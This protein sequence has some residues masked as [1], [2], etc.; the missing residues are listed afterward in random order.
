[1]LRCFKMVEEIFKAKLRSFVVKTCIYCQLMKL[2]VSKW[3]NL[4]F[5]INIRKNTKPQPTS[6]QR[7]G[8]KVLPKTHQ[9]TTGKR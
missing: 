9:T 8:F 5:M 1:M 6:V 3:T 2:I 4:L 7:S